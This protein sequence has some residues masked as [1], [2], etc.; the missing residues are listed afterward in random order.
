MDEFPVLVRYNEAVNVIHKIQTKNEQPVI[1][2]VSA[3]N[4]FGFPTSFRG[5]EKR[6]TGALRVHSSKGLGYVP[7]SDLSQG[8]ALARKF[9]V[10][11]SQTTSEHAGEPGKDGR[12]KLLSTVK[13]LAPG[14]ICT[15]SYITI[16]A[17]EN[18]AEAIHLRNYLLTKFAR[19]LI[20]QAVSSIHLSREK[21]MFLPLQDFSVSWT[22]K[23][24]YTKYSFKADEIALIESLIRP[25][26]ANDE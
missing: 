2:I 25:M 20:L 19:F 4:P 15:F 6:M 8:H 3:I 21:F 13:V 9:K 1:G 18:E 17:F 10:M 16:G 11:V 5:Q 26:E 24:L 22:D 23:A 7:Q 12:F 14:E